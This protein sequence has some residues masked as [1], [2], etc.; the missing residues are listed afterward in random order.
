M[1]KHP[2][3]NEFN[4]QINFTQINDTVIKLPQLGNTKKVGGTPK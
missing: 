4:T 2:K 3:I 1:R